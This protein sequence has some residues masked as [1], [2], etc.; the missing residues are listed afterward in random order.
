MN[1]N[2]EILFEWNPFVNVKLVT[3]YK[4]IT[5]ILG[6]QFQIIL[7]GMIEEYELY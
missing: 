3:N 6:L 5:L 4:E 1:L 7:N 2:P